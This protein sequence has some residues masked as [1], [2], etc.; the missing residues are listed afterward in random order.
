MESSSSS[1]TDPI[2]IGASMLPFSVDPF[3]NGLYF[4]L[5]KERGGSNYGDH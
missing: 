3:Y 5:A 1:P 4:L 2:V